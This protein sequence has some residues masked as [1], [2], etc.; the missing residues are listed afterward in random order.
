MQHKL[1]HGVL[2]MGHVR[3]HLIV[4]CMLATCAAPANGVSLARHIFN[5]SVNDDS[6]IMDS[7][8]AV[9]YGTSDILARTLGLSVEVRDGVRLPVLL[10]KSDCTGGSDDLG[11]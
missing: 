2:C 9:T 3:Q 6:T 8:C 7:T 10:S 11:M 1:R 5:V 4:A